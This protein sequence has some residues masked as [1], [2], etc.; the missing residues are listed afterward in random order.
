L[1]ASALALLASATW[2]ARRARFHPANG[3]PGGER[4]FPASSRALVVALIDVIVPR[5]ADAPSGSEVVSP[6]RLEKWAGAESERAR[7]YRRSWSALENAIEQQVPVADGTPDPR[8]L[9]EL[10]WRWYRRFR[11]R[12]PPPEAALF[13]QIR[14]DVL[15]L[16]YSSAAGWASV[17][18]SGPGQRNRR[19]PRA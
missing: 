14:R 8:A 13:E 10:C 9:D 19:T 6:E 12:R 16:Y 3:R 7:F 18:Y 5:D 17:G 1:I 11:T 2:F 15:K 4:V